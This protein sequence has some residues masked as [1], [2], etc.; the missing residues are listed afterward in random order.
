MSSGGRASRQKGNRAERALVRFLQDRGGHRE[1]FQ[2]VLSPVPTRIT[3]PAINV[4][5]RSLVCLA[6]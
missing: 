3:D 6:M 4:S 1:K 5:M 2:E